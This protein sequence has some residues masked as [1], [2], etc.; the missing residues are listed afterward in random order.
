MWT[1]E[2]IYRRILI[3][4]KKYFQIKLTGVENPKR[5][6]SVQCCLPLGP[7]IKDVSSKG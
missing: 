3:V 7:S 2:K 6:I 4:N 5:E 1:K